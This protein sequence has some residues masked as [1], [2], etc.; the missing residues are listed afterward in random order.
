MAGQFGI[1]DVREA[2]ERIKPYV[3][4]TPLEES[5]Y[6]GKNGRRYFF[7]LEC[8]QTVKSFKIRSAISKMSTLDYAEGK[9]G[10]DTLL[11]S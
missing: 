6:L 9:G 4:K 10:Q 3:Y 1:K 2:Y 11:W 8:A 5:L 7:K